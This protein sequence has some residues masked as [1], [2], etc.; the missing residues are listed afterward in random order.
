MVP[1]HRTEKALA[2][3]LAGVIPCEHR[4]ERRVLSGDMTEGQD[5]WRERLPRRDL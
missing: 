4:G 3:Q 1:A 5:R 2:R